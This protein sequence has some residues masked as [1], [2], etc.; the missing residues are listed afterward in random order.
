MAHVSEVDMA[1]VASIQTVFQ[2]SKL[3]RAG[4]TSRLL[5]GRLDGRQAWRTDARGA[6]DIFKDRRAQTTTKVNVHLLV[7][8][9]GSMTEPADGT[10][11]HIYGEPAKATRSMKAQDTT[12]TL[13]MAFRRIPTVRLHVWQHSAGS[14]GQMY[15]KKVYGDGLNRIEE[16]STHEGLKGGGNADGFA[17]QWVGEKALREARP[18]EHTI[19]I[20][21]SDGLPSV[22]GQ[23]ASNPDLITFSH[24]VSTRL[25]QK[26]AIVLSVLIAAGQDANSNEMYGEENVMEFKVGSPSAWADLARDMATVFGK[27]LR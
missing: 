17:L 2:R 16:M 23:H 12:A 15:I 14:D 6:V 3:S 20:V 27:V 21:V 8:A 4:W 5:E 26:G 13:A 11:R 9:S 10:R 18:D 19:I 25:R 22:H 7:D 24:V 1:T